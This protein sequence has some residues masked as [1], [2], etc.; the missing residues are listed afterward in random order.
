MSKRFECF[1][2]SWSVSELSSALHISG[3]DVVEYFKDGRRMSF[4]LERSIERE[5]GGSRPSSESES[6]DVLDSQGMKWEV[7]CVTKGG[8][9]FSPSYMVG[10]GREFV[11]KGFL[12]KLNAVSG[13]IVGDIT[14]FPEVQ[15]WRIPSQQVLTWWEKGWLGTNA[16][17]SRNKYL[18]MVKEKISD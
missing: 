7:R 8:M 4:I 15:C 18:L 3:E 16:K 12:E 14:G 5:I 11:E 17:V 2:F 6:Y 9:Y 13:Y 1:S 10:S